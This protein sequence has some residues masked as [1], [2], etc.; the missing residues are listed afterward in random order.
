MRRATLWVAALLWTACGSANRPANEVAPG[1]EAAPE[2]AA[3]AAKVVPITSS[4]PEA[5]TAFQKGLV[6]QENFRVTDAT[7][8]YQRALELDPSFQLAR[9]HLGEVTPGNKGLELIRSAAAA[10][11]GLPEAERTQIEA[12]RAAAEGDQAKAYGLYAK[13]AELAPDDWRAQSAYGSVAMLRHDLGVATKAFTRASEL[14]PKAGSAW[15][16]LG[17]AR[18]RAKDYDGAIEAFDH[19]IAVA[20][21]EANAWDSKGE[22]LLRAGRLD[23]AIAAFEK[24]GQLDP[25]FWMAFEGAAQARFLKGDSAGGFAALDQAEGAAPADYAVAQVRLHRAWARYALGDPAA[26]NTALSDLDA[27]TGD[28][29]LAAQHARVPVNRAAMALMDDRPKDTLAMLPEAVTRGASL[30]GDEAAMLKLN[31]EVLALAAEAKSGQADKAEAHLATI[32]GLVAKNPYVAA[33]GQIARGLLALAKDDA[34]GAVKTLSAC[35]DEEAVCGMYLAQAQD[36]AGDSAAATAT[37]ERVR[38]LNSRDP[39]YLGVWSKV[40]G[41]AHAQP[42]GVSD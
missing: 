16:M 8:A 1:P 39:A 7:T 2:Q 14:E 13:V 15:N 17:Y 42:G 33:D 29:A 5:V 3:P 12:M 27:Y 22:V 37:R 18:A 6:A 34:T 26:A 25:K 41:P 38:T 9:A 24:A 20:P 36:E 11:A 23:E 28:H 10:S 30:E 21:T 32:D 35:D 40:G 31:T 4:S 19:Y